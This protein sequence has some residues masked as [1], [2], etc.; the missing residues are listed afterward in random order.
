VKNVEVKNAFLTALNFSTGNNSSGIF[1]AG[2]L[3]AKRAE[4]GTN[5][6]DKAGISPIQL[7]S[8]WRTVIIKRL[9][10]IKII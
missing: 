3:N 6:N 10:T 7:L 9:P 8:K 5:H 2:D 4:W 1:K